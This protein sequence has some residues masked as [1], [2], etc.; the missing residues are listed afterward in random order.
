MKVIAI[1][2]SPRKSWNTVTLLN[3]ALEGAASRGASTEL[4]HLYDLD[5]KGCISCFA[6]KR[7]GGKSLGRSAFR[8][9]LTPVL[10]KIEQADAV[11]LGSPIYFHNITAGMRAL[12][13]RM[14]FQYLQYDAAN[15]TVF[16]RKLPVGFI[17]TMNVTET[18]LQDF[19]YP[20]LLSPVEQAATRVFG[21]AESLFVTDTC[22]FDNYDNYVAPRFDGA[23]KAKRRREEFPQDCAKAYA[24]G[25][26]FASGIF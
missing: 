10:E 1:N 7:K 21:H 25:V 16:P 3:S 26:K 4:V 11:I 13:E 14:T 19:N 9:G 24:M 20:G 8:D 15:P 12:V 6:C 2:G 5:F 23:A 18:M 17:Y 22:Q